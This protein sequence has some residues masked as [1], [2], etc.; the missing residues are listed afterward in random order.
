M[1]TMLDRK[2]LQRHTLKCWKIPTDVTKILPAEALALNSALSTETQT[3]PIWN[4]PCL[5]AEAMAAAN[6]KVHVTDANSSHKWTEEVCF[7][8]A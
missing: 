3:S 6:F 7:V 5:L 2:T 4:A 8:S 1:S